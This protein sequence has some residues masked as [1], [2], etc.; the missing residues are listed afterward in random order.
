MLVLIFADIMTT[1]PYISEPMKEHCFPSGYV[2]GTVCPLSIYDLN[3]EAA[4]SS[5]TENLCFIRH[6]KEIG[7]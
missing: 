6:P 7:S 2:A 4:V 3:P 1:I 5:C